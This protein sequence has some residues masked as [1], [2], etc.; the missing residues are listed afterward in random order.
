[1]SANGGYTG[2]QRRWRTEGFGSSGGGYRVELFRQALQNSKNISFVG[3]LENG[4]STVQNQTFPKKHEVH[5]GYTIDSDTGHSGISGS[6]TAQALA[7]YTASQ[8]N[9]PAN[10]WTSSE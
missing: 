1:V 7:N 5:G 10:F 9:G 3:S 8:L 6:I 4:A 2:G